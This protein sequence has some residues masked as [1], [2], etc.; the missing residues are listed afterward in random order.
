MIASAN[1]R[2]WTGYGLVF[3]FWIGIIGSSLA[4]HASPLLLEAP[5]ETPTVEPT[6]VAEKHAPEI[7]IDLELIGKMRIPYPRDEVVYVV[8]SDRLICHITIVDVDGERVGV[9]SINSYSFSSSRWYTTEVT[10]YMNVRYVKL[11]MPKLIRLGYY[12]IS[13]ECGK[14]N[15]PELLTSRV[16]KF[17]SVSA[18]PLIR[19]QVESTGPVYRHDDERQEFLGVQAGGTLTYEIDIFNPTRLDTLVTDV[20]VQSDTGTPQYRIAKHEEEFLHR[21]TLT[22]HAPEPICYIKNFL[23]AEIVAYTQKAQTEK[24]C[25]L[26]VLGGEELPVYVVD[27]RE[28][29]HTLNRIY[30][31]NYYYTNYRDHVILFYRDSLEAHFGG[32]GRKTYISIGDIDGD[33]HDDIV[34]TLSPKTKKGP[35]P[36]IVRC[37]DLQTQKTIGH[38]FVAFQP[39]DAPVNYDGGEVKSTIGNF[40]GMQPNQIALAQG[41][42]SNGVVRLF[43]YTGKPAPNAFRIVGQFYGLASAYSRSSAAGYSFTSLAVGWTISRLVSVRPH[44]VFRSCSTHPPGR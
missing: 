16:I 24:N 27:G 15:Y 33:G 6:P 41:K 11:T 39:G 29:N 2:K 40:T 5:T 34:A 23:T 18:K 19:T 12:E 44:P 22:V 21:Y 17:E 43:Q 38:T 31:L 26:S 13:V 8:P 35:Y 14:Y 10:K 28:S 4:S 20:L 37:V 3:G 32:A 9:P 30:H 42:G 1:S 25:S 36:N 7:H